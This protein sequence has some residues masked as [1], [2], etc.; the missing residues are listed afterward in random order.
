VPGALG[1]APV[2]DATNPIFVAASESAHKQFDDMLKGEKQEDIDT[3][4]ASILNAAVQWYSNQADLSKPIDTAL[5]DRL[6]YNA[7]IW[8]EAFGSAIQTQQSGK[9]SWGPLGMML[10][11]KPIAWDT[12]DWTGIPA[13]TSV[14]APAGFAPTMKSPPGL[15]ANADWS[16]IPWDLVGQ[17]SVY[18]D[19]APPM[20][21]VS[22]PS[23]V[24]QAGV[25]AAFE[26]AIK[27]ILSTQ[28]CQDGY[29]H[30][31]VNDSTTPCVSICS[32]PAMWDPNR[33]Q[34][35]PLGSAYS[36]AAKTC[37]CGAGNTYDSTKNTCSPGQPIVVNKDD[38]KLAPEKKSYVVPVVIG[39]GVVGAAL[40][41]GRGMIFGK[42]TG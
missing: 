11:D 33:K 2:L 6:A 12:I 5:M 8:S 39:V 41:L 38:S 7:G 26:D 18:L 31:D 1:A 20:V 9:L 17:N 29:R 3:F 25:Q 27:G 32:D 4:L 19:S 24:D 30:A 34:C 23:P 21:P 10:S 40:W 22:Y 15:P 13:P 28:E 37:D 42:K 16:W 36:A 14:P 35:C